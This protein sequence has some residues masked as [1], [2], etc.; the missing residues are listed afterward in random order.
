MIEMEGCECGGAG[1]SS[2]TTQDLRDLFAIFSRAAQVY[3]SDRDAQLGTLMAIRDELGR[4]R[5]FK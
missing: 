2:M 3:S 5:D 1:I 4:R